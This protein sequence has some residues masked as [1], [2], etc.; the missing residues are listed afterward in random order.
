M[1]N[2]RLI[3][4]GLICV[5]GLGLCIGLGVLLVN[6]IFAFT[7]PVVDASQQFLDLLGQGKITEAYASSA[8]GF[9]TQQSETS[10]ADA[11]KQLGLT[12]FSTV[13]WQNRQIVNQEGMAE[14]NVTTR[15]GETKPIAIRLVQEKGKWA[16]VGLRYGGVD[17]A[18]FKTSTTVPAQA[19]LERMVADA[20]LSFNQAIKARDFAAFYDKLS[21]LWKN[22][23][24]AEG[25]Q[26][27]FQDFIDKD[28]DISGIKSVKPKITMAGMSN[29]SFLS[30]A[31]YYPT[32]P[33]QVRFELKHVN[34]NGSWK[35]TGIS[36]S[37]GKEVDSE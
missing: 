9:R 32:K 27:V 22:E 10:F 34:E 19:D 15:K 33:S 6:R 21:D 14:G 30:I 31:G 1:R 28:I 26:K 29:E 2:N 20:L 4:C 36:V 16:V 7:Q 3:G 23:T 13:T 25:L 8:D 17:M 12:D 18:T 11:V 5:L 35:L 24:T 37:V